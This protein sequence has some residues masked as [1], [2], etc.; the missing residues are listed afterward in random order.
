[1]IRSRKLKVQK[2]YQIR[3]YG[4]VTVPEIRLTGKWLIRSGFKEGQRVNIQQRKDMIIIT[5]DR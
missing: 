5:I 4:M 1:M 2:K 3:T